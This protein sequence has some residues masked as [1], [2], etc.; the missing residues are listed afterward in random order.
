VHAFGF[1]TI[2]LTVHD[3]RTSAHDLH[4]AVAQHRAVAHAVLVRQGAF[5][6]IRDD[7]HIAVTVRIEAAACLYMVIIDDT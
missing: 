5:E 6:H 1:R 3:T 4:I 7:F 2:E